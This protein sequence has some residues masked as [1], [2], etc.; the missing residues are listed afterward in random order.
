MKDNESEVMPSDVPGI[1]SGTACEIVSES[2]ELYVTGD[3]RATEVVGLCEKERETVEHARASG[4]EAERPG[5]GSAESD[6]GRFQ[7]I[8]AGTSSLQ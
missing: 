3:D 8:V 1:G 7:G 2:G 4:W 5:T 6:N